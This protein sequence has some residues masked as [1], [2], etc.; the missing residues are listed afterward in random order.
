[1]LAGEANASEGDAAAVDHHPDFLALV[2]AAAVDHHRRS[3]DFPQGVAEGHHRSFGKVL[4]AACLQGSLNLTDTEVFRHNLHRRLLL[5]ILHPVGQTT[6][7]AAVLQKHMAG[8]LE[9]T[10]NLA[11][12]M[13]IDRG[14][15]GRRSEH[16]RLNHNQLQESV[17]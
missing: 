2:E 5:P 4:V 14:A 9:V 13:V 3:K 8:R 7:P 16:W 1:M 6:V 12:A 17:D 11:G 15:E 10:G